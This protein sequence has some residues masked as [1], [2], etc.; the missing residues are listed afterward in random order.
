M[1]R[2]SI[3]TSWLTASPRVSQKIALKIK[4]DYIFFFSFIEWFDN[5]N[6]TSVQL[7]RTKKKTLN[8]QINIFI[9]MKLS[10][11]KCCI[12]SLYKTFS[13]FDK[14]AALILQTIDKWKVVVRFDENNE[15]KDK[16]I[17]FISHKFIFNSVLMSKTRYTVLLQRG[18]VIWHECYF[19]AHSFHIFF[20]SSHKMFRLVLATIK[21][22]SLIYICFASLI[23]RN[24]TSIQSIR[25]WPK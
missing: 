14:T 17:G 12:F 13:L 25:R 3:I 9:Q 6:L 18:T 15:P 1:F 11:L 22:S 20:L 4:L 24:V 5:W 2:S 8:S 23:L 10:C 16:Q 19:F 21:Q 7:N